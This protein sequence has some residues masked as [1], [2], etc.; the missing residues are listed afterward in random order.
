MFSHKSP[1][2][3]QFLGRHFQT[4]LLCTGVTFHLAIFQTSVGAEI[5]FSHE[6]LPILKSKCA[7]CHTNGTYKGGLSMDTRSGLLDSG[8]IV[9]GKSSDSEFVERLI[10]DDEDL[11]MPK[12]APQLSDAEIA[13]LRRWVDEN[14]PWEEGFSF[15]EQ[16]Y[17]APLAPR[18]PALPPAVED[19]THP[20][21]RVV[22]QYFARADIER[23]GPVSD[24]RFLRRLTLDLTGQLPTRQ[25][26][27]EFQ[28]S[29]DG[30]KRE[31]VAQLL[32]GDSIA[33]ADHWITFWND[34]LR[35][36][37]QGTGY[38]DGGRKEIT[39]WLYQSL[40]DNKPYDQFVHELISPTAG[41]EG[42]I[43]GIKW[44]GRV[45]ASQVRELQFAQN[46][47]QVM[48][49]INL[50][51]ASCHDSFINDWKLADA[52]GLAAI[53][54][55]RKL[56]VHRCDKPTGQ[57]AQASFLFPELGN[58]DPLSPKESRLRELAELI[59]SDANGRFARTIVNR[60][61]DRLMGHGIVHP[62]DMMGNEPW[63]EDL[64]DWLAFDFAE[65]GYDLK[66]LLLR[67][68][69]SKIYQS[70]T[71]PLASNHD[72]G[73][74]VF[75]GPVAKRM[76]AEQFQ[77]AVWQLTDS[78]PR[79]TNSEF[80]FR[81]GRPVRAAL[82]N[83]SLLTRALGRPNREQVVTTRPSELTTLQ[84]L[85]L[86][87]G[88]MLA[89]QIRH[90]IEK[91]R[92]ESRLSRDPTKMVSNLYLAAVSRQPNQSEIN[93]AAELVRNANP[94]APGI[95]TESVADLY[96]AVMMLPEFQMVR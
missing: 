89:G 3:T 42:F 76:T 11:R 24:A 40:L 41:S 74:F 62:V 23:P 86:T 33:Y 88:E 56:E 48:L 65:N 59:T 95:S 52:Y 14:L 58:V 17:K 27:T 66:R 5:D 32:L 39:R 67:I 82:V 64:L 53:I 49:G 2:P 96:W 28:G 30:N 61:W 79:K 91:L 35:N 92:A 80:G 9:A 34:L 57:I 10:T 29:K 73:Q 55:D 81:A 50:K 16:S 26:L 22:D 7:D 51:C 78:Y 21:D 6:V 36:D 31:R 45:N 18:N 71:V 44:R 25:M 13:I 75:Q 46:V 84:A 15:R 87:N 37:Y 8:A 77:D 94:S 1:F 68:V 72:S 69:S 20:I 54:S 43:K 19:R 85:Y 12:D 83:S 90:G 38:I 70:A 93:A 47:S 63:S 60:F 4:I